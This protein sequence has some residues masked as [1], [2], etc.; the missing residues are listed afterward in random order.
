LQAIKTSIDNIEN[1]IGTPKVFENYDGN[2][3][4]QSTV[5]RNLEIIGEVT[6]DF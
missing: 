2:L 4:V 1:F 5:E 3:L 6:K